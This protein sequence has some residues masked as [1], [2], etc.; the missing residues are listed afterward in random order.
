MTTFVAHVVTVY[1]LGV[2]S[3]ESTVV[4]LGIAAMV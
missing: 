1:R 4:T 3:T 2:F